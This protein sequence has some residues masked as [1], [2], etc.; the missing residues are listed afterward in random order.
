MALIGQA[1][2]EKKFSEKGG[3]IHVYSPG[4]GV[5]NPLGSI[6]FNNTFNQSIKSFAASFP[7]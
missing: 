7:H 6:F 4:A 2:L 3:H 5:D 1:D